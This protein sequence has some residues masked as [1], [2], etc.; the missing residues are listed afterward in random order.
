M[1]DL[2]LKEEEDVARDLSARRFSSV[3]APVQR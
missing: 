3:L 1:C 2:V